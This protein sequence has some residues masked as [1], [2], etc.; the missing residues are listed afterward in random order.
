GC[1]LDLF[2]PKK[3]GNLD[4]TFCLDC[5]KACPHDNVALK[6]VVPASTLT[7]DPD[8][9]SIGKLS[10]RTDIVVFATMMIFGAFVNPAGMV[11][12]VMAWEHSWHAC[13]GAGAMPLVIAALIVGGVVILPGA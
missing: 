12:P 10:K 7:L 1:E 3:V 4:C 9:S 5:V 6:A 13:L 2:Q 11:T 8:R